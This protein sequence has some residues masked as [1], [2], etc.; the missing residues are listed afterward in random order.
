MVPIS[1]FSST[2]MSGNTR[3]PS[4]AWAMP[5]LATKCADLRLMS[6]PR[7]RICPAAARG[8]PKIDISRVDLPA[9]LAPISATVSPSL[10]SSETFF[11]AWIGP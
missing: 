3:R 9:P 11:S 4:G 10:T 1:R 8:W 2:L 5:L 7:N 6:W